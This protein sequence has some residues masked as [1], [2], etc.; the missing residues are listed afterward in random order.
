[1]EEYANQMEILGVST[2]DQEEIPGVTTP[3]QEEIPVVETPEEE[4]EIPE[5]D[6]PEEEDEE[7]EITLMD[8]NTE[9][10]GVNQPTGGNNAMPGNPPGHI[11]T[12]DNNTHKMETVDNKP[13]TEEDNITNEE[14]IQDEE[15]FEF[16]V[17][18][19]SPTEQCVWEASQ[20]HGIC[21][22]RQPSFE[23]KNTQTTTT[24][25]SWST[26]LHN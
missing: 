23:Q 9:D 18:S 3:D 13:D 26:Y 15:G 12:N 20:I 24:Q 5:A 19:P 22:R 6:I 1:M 25:T 17:N 2:P 11:P 8:Q 4:E 21:P 14:T 10:P 7:T 16:Q